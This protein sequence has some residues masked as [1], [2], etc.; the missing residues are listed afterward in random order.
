MCNENCSCQGPCSCREEQETAASARTCGMKYID[1]LSG[2]ELYPTEA[3]MCTV[4]KN[5]TREGCPNY[6]PNCGAKV[7][8]EIEDAE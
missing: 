6:C 3:W 8:E 7:I 1:M 2:G 5:V 4:C